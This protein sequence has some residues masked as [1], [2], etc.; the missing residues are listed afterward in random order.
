MLVHAY[1]CR[2]DAARMCVPCRPN[3]HFPPNFPALLSPPVHASICPNRQFLAPAQRLTCSC[4]VSDAV[5]KVSSP[6]RFRCFTVRRFPEGRRG[7]HTP[8]PWRHPLPRGLSW[9]ASR[10]HAHLDDVLTEEWLGALH[11]APPPDLPNHN[12]RMPVHVQHGFAA[13]P[14]IPFPRLRFAETLRG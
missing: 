2:S 12:G 4:Q 8:P 13:L 6:Y 10:A 9:T 5:Q 7:W 11:A 14:A 3:A 1:R